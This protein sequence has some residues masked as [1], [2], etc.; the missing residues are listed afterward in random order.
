[1]LMTIAADG[2]SSPRP[3]LSNGWAEAT[4]VADD[5][6]ETACDGPENET[7]VA[8]S[9][10]ALSINQYIVCQTET[11]LRCVEQ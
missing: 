4:L 8:H 10:P 9:T 2:T 3:L 7:I 11:K 1:M 5:M 6:I